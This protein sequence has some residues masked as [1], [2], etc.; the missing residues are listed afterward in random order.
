MNRSPCVLDG[1]LDR[2]NF[3]P[4][5]RAQYERVIGEWLEFAG[6]D[7]R[8]W[9]RL[10]AQNFYDDCLSR[11]V[12]VGTANNYIACLRYVS[13]WFHVQHG[14]EDFALIQ[15]R[16]I[17]EEGRS[18]RR[19]LT[20]SD[21]I[22]LLA[23]CSGSLPIAKRPLDRRDRALLVLGL[24]T[25]M[26]SMS[27]EGSH[28]ENVRERPYP[29]ITV[30]IKGRGGRKRFDVPLS[31]TAMSALDDWLGWLRAHD[32][33]DGPVFRR[34]R[35]GIDRRGQR[36]YAVADGISQVMIYKI[37]SRRAKEA[38]IAHVHPHLLRHTFITWRVAS[39]LAAPFIAAITGHSLSTR[40][41]DI[42]SNGLGEIATYFDLKA[43][44]ETARQSTPPWL[45][46]HVH[47]MLE[48]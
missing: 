26:R 12:K 44:A 24:E 37:I 8:G 16:D 21:V 33:K 3:S 13:H 36:A 5:T 4:V 27:L 46:G 40:H 6:L 1:I 42:P 35:P 28:I 48:G 30:P 7:P 15:I 39:G 23:T 2:S 18:V 43:Y 19:A 17:I 34:L 31:D 9:T 38:G 29:F 20:Q 14:G 47:Q 32:V 11:G 10:R 45:A 41:Q 22:A 25:G